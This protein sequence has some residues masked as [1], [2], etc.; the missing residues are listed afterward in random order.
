MENAAI[1]TDAVQRHLLPQEHVVWQGRPSAGLILRPIEVLLIPFSLLWGGFAIFWNISVWVTPTPLPFKLFGL[2][3]LVIGLYMIFGRF[4][5]DMALRK[6]LLYLVTDKRILIF[7]NE[8]ASTSR[9]LDIRHLP[10][11]ELNE[12]ADGNGTIRF[13]SSGGMFSGVNSGGFAIWSPTFDPTPQ[14]LGIESVRK[15]YELI[16]KQSA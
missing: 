16:Q 5:V 10:S 14:F 11:L 1:M 4:L 7:R 9:S 12:R 13:G 15:V 8:G 6:N 3:F 2:P